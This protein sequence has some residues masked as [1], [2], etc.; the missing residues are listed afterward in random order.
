MCFTDESAEEGNARFGYR[1]CAT[2]AWVFVLGVLY[3]EMVLET[4]VSWLFVA[5]RIWFQQ[6]LSH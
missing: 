6:F 5:D 2:L 4:K 1:A 3:I